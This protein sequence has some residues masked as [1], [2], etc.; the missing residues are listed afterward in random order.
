MKLA[1][2][3]LAAL[4]A[5]TAAAA[6][7]DKPAAVQVCLNLP[8]GV[9]LFAE[10]A[11]R[12]YRAH[13]EGGYILDFDLTLNGKVPERL[14]K[15]GGTCLRAWIRAEPL[16]TI[17]VDFGKTDLNLKPASKSVSLKL[18]PDLWY[19]GGALD[20]ERAPLS[21]VTT[22]LPGKLEMARLENAE[23]S[24]GAF[25]IKELGKV[26]AGRYTVK[27]EPPPPPQGSCDIT[28]KV[29][30][31]GTVR[32]DSRADVYKE[33][34]DTYQKEF[35][36]EVAKSLK[37]TCNQAQAL[38]IELRIVDG[39]YRNPW[40]PKVT[41]ITRREREPRYELV[42][43]GKRE[44]FVEGQELPI[45]YG[46]AIVLEEQ[47]QVAAAAPESVQASAQQ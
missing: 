22:S 41:K 47:Q 24:K 3:A 43:D 16:G 6:G 39:A 7:N 13:P 28:L 4:T 20:T 42:I 18:K 30:A 34:V 11:K 23:W 31:S 45:A 14:T 33:L 32:P 44:P 8:S 5:S 29:E 26:A 15:N 25:P 2:V 17:A 9:P 1:L 10:A 21:K 35:A 38:E 27:Y 40:S 37:A 46:Q 12:N 36:P 19:D